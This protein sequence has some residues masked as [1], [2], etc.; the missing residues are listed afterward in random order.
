MIVK[1][2]GLA[3]LM[4]ALCF[5]HINYDNIVLLVVKLIHTLWSSPKQ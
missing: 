5:C 2:V 1:N 4:P 3:E